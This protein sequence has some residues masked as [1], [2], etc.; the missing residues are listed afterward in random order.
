MRA[1]EALRSRCLRR[2]SCISQKGR[3]RLNC[4]ADLLPPFC[5]SQF[6]PERF[7]CPIGEA[8]SFMGDANESDPAGKTSMSGCGNNGRPP[9][10]G[11][12]GLST[13]V[14]AL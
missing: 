6:D 12:L 1:E 7:R 13:A 11:T 9:F 5:K 3:V 4:R 14:S 8:D 2:S 10:F